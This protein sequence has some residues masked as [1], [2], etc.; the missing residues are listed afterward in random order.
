[1]AQ[2]R[3]CQ[4]ATHV[5]PL[6]TSLLGAG[7]LVPTWRHAGHRKAGTQPPAL[8]ASCCG[9]EQGQQVGRGCSRTEVGGRQS[10]SVPRLRPQGTESVKS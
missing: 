9:V 8:G 10:C 2:L 3:G 1:M 6:P 4:Q 5:H 7:G